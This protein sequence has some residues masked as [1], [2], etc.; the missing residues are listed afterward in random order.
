V[1]S[2]EQP[3]PM[4]ETEESGSEPA[5][6]T[7]VT[8]LKHKMDFLRNA[9][10]T[11]SDEEL[12]SPVVNRFLIEEIE[13]LDAELQEAKGYRER[14]HK[15]DKEAELARKDLSVNQSINITD[16]TILA[17]GSAGLGASPSYISV[18][19]YGWV[20]FGLSLLIVAI[21]IYRTRK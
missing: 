17:I 7:P 19:K 10:R 8:A 11:L 18:S 2:D 16:A 1:T 15:A 13:R 3:A 20:F 12:C 21:A 6:L 4:D 5:E 9:R 14:F